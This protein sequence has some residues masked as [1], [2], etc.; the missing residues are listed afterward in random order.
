MV[1][2]RAVGVRNRDCYKICPLQRW[3]REVTP[4]TWEV[5]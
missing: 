1:Y 5:G 3:V 4:L 2:I